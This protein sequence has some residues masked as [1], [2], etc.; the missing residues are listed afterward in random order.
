MSFFLHI[1]G[2]LSLPNDTKELA[3]LHD[4]VMKHHAPVELVARNGRLLAVRPNSIESGEEGLFL[5][6]LYE[7]SKAFRGAVHGEFEVWWPMAVESGPQWWTIEPEHGRFTVTE[8][9]IVREAPV[10]YT[11]ESG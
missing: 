10:E 11:H 6:F 4:I 3:R 5:L 9:T 7:V 1:T 2:G 8:S